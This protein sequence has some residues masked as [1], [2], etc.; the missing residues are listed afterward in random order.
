MSPIKNITS[1]E[2]RKLMKNEDLIILDVRAP[3]EFAE[4][5]IKNSEN[6]DFTDPD[7]SDNLKKLDKNK[8]YLVYCKTGRRGAMALETMKNI[9]FNNLYNLIGGY[10]A[11]NGD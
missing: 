8:K 6:L 1:I 2:A 10:D 11:W 3:W 9:G 4:G 5:H 7:F